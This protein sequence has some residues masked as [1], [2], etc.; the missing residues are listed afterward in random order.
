MEFK[1][2]PL[3]RKTF[4]VTK[5]IKNARLYISAAGYYEVFLNGKKV[6]NHLLDPGY[7]HFDKRMLYVTHDVTKL[8]NPKNNCFSAVLGNGWYNIQSLAVWNFDQAEWR[9][10]PRLIY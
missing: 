2:S 8:I 9:N 3:F 6:G 1:P 7:T 5:K 4:S 10:R